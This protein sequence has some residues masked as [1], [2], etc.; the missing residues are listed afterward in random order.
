MII[1][2]SDVHYILMAPCTA[3]SNNISDAS[4]SKV[5]GRRGGVL[6]SVCPALAFAV[7]HLRPRVLLLILY[8][9]IKD[10]N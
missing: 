10:T 5:G 3:S 2:A 7:Q 6:R 8:H 9:P 4:Q 1:T